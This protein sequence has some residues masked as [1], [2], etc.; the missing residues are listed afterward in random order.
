M[1]NIRGSGSDLPH[2]E[3]NTEAAA[4]ASATAEPVGA[5]AIY[6]LGL[7]RMPE[8]RVY[9]RRV[10]D[11]TVEMLTDAHQAVLEAERAARVEVLRTIA[12]EHRAQIDRL[13]AEN[14]ALREALLQMKGGLDATRTDC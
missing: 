12:A 9:S 4:A 14:R 7:A 10:D 5:A 1:N 8:R 3:R 2:G 6:A 13:T 11:V